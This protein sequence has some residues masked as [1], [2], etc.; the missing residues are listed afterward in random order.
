MKKPLTSIQ[1]T[2]ATP[3]VKKRKRLQCFAERD[4][5]GTAPSTS[6]S[7]SNTATQVSGNIFRILVRRSHSQ[8]RITSCTPPG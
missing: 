7:T 1:L 4:P 3:P 5:S 2:L 8:H 6:S